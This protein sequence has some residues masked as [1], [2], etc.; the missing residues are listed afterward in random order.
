MSD[1]R[2]LPLLAWGDAL[3]AT[4]RIAAAA[5]IIYLRQRQQAPGLRRA[6]R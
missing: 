1:A 6:L 5:T 3:R 2:N 4:R